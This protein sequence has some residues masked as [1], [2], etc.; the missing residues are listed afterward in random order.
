MKSFVEGEKYEI[1]F[2]LEN[3]GNEFFPGGDL[4]FQ[5][6]WPSEQ[7]TK[8]EFPIPPLKR[9]ERYETPEASP[10]ALSS[11]F[12]LVYIK[13]RQVKNEEGEDHKVEFY[14][15]KRVED[16]IDISESISKIKV[17]TWEEI[18][19]F[20]ALIVASISLAIIALEKV[21]LW[22]IRWIT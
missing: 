4:P 13:L 16:Y 5:I 9:N 12:G 18:Y 22:L 21:L 8:G 15:G 2:R 6:S 3:I 19:E 20:W 1:S 10:N 7:Y 17:K 14:S 11:G